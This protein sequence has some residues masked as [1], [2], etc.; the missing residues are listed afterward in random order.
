MFDLDN[1]PIA[2]TSTSSPIPSSSNS[3]PHS[4]TSAADFTEEYLLLLLSDSNLP[5]GGFVASSG[6]ESF[7][8]H[9]YLPPSSSSSSTTKHGAAT[10]GSTEKEKGLVEFVKKSLDN[11]SKLNSEIVI[12]SHQLVQAYRLPGRGKG[13]ERESVMEELLRVDR[14]CEDMIL[15]QVSKRASIAQGNALLSLY[16]RALAPTTIDE[17]EVGE[18][19]DLIRREIRKGERGGWKGHQSTSFGI[20]MAAVGLSLNRSLHLFLFL[21]ARSILSSA[22]RLNVIGPYSAHRLLLWDIKQLVE[23][24]TSHLTSRSSIIDRKEEE[25]VGMEL[26]NDRDWWDNDEEWAFLNEKEAFLNE[27]EAGR[28]A[29]VST[30]PL[31]EIVASRHDQLFTKVFNS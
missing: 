24:A 28:S 13:K 5:T 9:G 6:L 30:W 2:S 20:V 22:V 1:P 15:N 11:Y 16:S 25:E 4:T 19:V 26:E 8:Q 18:L 17:G 23:E 29:P 14:L 12:R 3:L 31:G 21:H 10:D 7:I 27:K